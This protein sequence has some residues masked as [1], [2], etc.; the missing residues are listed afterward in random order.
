MFE[1]EMT[2]VGTLIT[3]VDRRSLTG[4]STKSTF[5]VASNSRRFDRAVEGWVDGDSLFV[6]VTAWRGLAENVHASFRVGDPIIVHGRVYSDS[7]EKDGRRQWI[8]R[9]EASAVGPDL[10]RA[11]A[12]VTRMR[13]N[14]A[15]TTAPVTGHGGSDDPWMSPV[16]PQADT[17]DVVSDDEVAVTDCAVTNGAV[18]NGAVTNGAGA[19]SV[20]TNG[21]RTEGAGGLVA[22]AVGA[23]RAGA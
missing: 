20:G 23:G 4:G 11:T 13:R 14:G 15:D 12:V 16:A 1:T 17:D 6:S 3:P 2:V 19:N 21:L 5:R 8:T 18:T 9:L 7:Y 22:G 10:A